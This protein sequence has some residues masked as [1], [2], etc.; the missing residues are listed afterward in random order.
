MIRR[1]ARKRRAVRKAAQNW[2][3]QLNLESLEA[4]QLL[5]GDVIINEISAVNGALPDEDGDT[6]DW[7]ELYNRGDEPVDLGGSYLTDDQGDLRKWRF[8]QSVAVGPGEFLIVYA[9]GKDRDDA[10]GVLHT[11]FQLSSDGEYLALVAAD[12]STVV[13][14]FSPEFP[15]QFGGVTYGRFSRE[16]TTILADG[17]SAAKYIATTAELD[18]GIGSRWTGGQAFDD[19]AWTETSASLGFAQD[20][21]DSTRG[22]F[23]TP[24]YEVPA[25]TSGNQAYSG[26]IGMDFVVTSPI[27]VTSLGVFDDSSDGLRSRVS[28][29]LWSRDDGGTPNDFRDDSGAELLASDTL[30]GTRDL[31][32]GGS[33]YAELDEP[34]ELQPGPYSIVAYGFSTLDRDAVGFAGE[35]VGETADTNAIRF[36]GSA[37]L[38]D[39]SDEFPL[40]PDVGPANRYGAGSFTFLTADDIGSA[41]PAR[42]G[43]VVA[44]QSPAVEGNAATGSNLGVDFQVIRPITVTELGVF[45]SGQDGIAGTLGVSLWSRTT[46]ELLAGKTFI[47]DAGVLEEGTGSRFLPLDEPVFLMPGDYSVVASGFFGNDLYVH[48]SRPGGAHSDLNDS[49]GAIVFEGTSRYNIYAPNRFLEEPHH[50]LPP[51]EDIG[52]VNRWSAGT[53]K[54]AVALLDHVETEV[55]A[56]V[57]D[58]SSNVYMRIPF[59][60]AEVDSFDGLRLHVNYDD[61]FVAYLNGVEVAR[62]NTPAEITWDAAATAV[63]TDLDV[64][65]TEV[66]DLSEHLSLL[67]PNTANVL[68]FQVLNAASDDPDLVLNPL[69]EAFANAG[70]VT[71]YFPEPTPGGPNADVFLGVVPAPEIVTA[72]GIVDPAELNEQGELRVE[73]VNALPDAQI[74]VTTDGS[75][76]SPSNGTLYDGTFSISGTTVLRAAAVKDGF[77]ESRTATAT[78]ILLDDVLATA[79]VPAGF[80][81]HWNGEPPDY[82]ISQDPNDLAAIAGDLSLSV[83]A[84]R[85]VIKESLQSL[86][87]MSIAGDI[88][89]IFGLPDGLYTNP[90]PRGSETEH[91]ASVEFYEADGT[92]GFQI[93]AGLRMMGWTSRIPQVSPKHS[94]RLLFRNE[95]GEGRLEYPLFPGS[96]ITTFDTLALRAN[97]RDS[98]ISDYPFGPGTGLWEE[99]DWGAMRSVAAYIRDQWSREVQADMGMTAAEGRFVHLYINGVYW[100]VYNPTERP[101]GAFAADRFGGDEDDYD[102]ITFCNPTSRATHGD[103]AVWNQLIA[104]V[105]DGLAGDAAY[106]RILGN[107][108]DGTRNPDL[109]VLLD[110]DTFIDFMIS[111]QYDATD[112]W[113]CNFYAFRER[114]QNDT[115]FRF[116]TWDNDLA[117]P[118]GEV[119][120]DRVDVDLTGTPKS[121]PWRFQAVLQQNSDYVMRFADRVQQHFFHDGALTPAA[122]AARW[123]RISDEIAPG[124]IAESARWGDYRRDVASAGPAE[125]YTKSIHWDAFNDHMLTN[126]FP[127][128]TDIVLDQMRARGLYPALAAPELSQHGGTITTGFDLSID[129]PDGTVYFTLDGSDPRAH[130]PNITLLN[131]DSIKRVLVPTNGSLGTNWTSVDFNHTSWTAGR[132]GV[133]YEAGFGDYLDFIDISTRDAM[134]TRS[135]SAYVRIPFN[136]A[137][138]TLPELG[139]LNLKMRY[140]DGFIAY[141]NG[142]EVARANAPNGAAWD[143]LANGGQADGTALVFQDFDLTP[144]LDQLQAGNNVLAIHGLNID[145]ASSDFLIS[146]ELVTGQ[147][148]EGV[149]SAAAQQYMGAITLDQS[150]KVKARVFD[151]SRWSALTEASFAVESPLR[152]SEIYYNPP[153]DIETTEFIEL[154]NTGVTDADLL[155]VGFVTDSSGAGID[156]VFQDGDSVL[157]LAAGQYIVIAK[158]PAAFRAAY[159]DLPA[160]ALIADRGFDGQLSNGGETLRLVDRGGST[161]QEFRYEDDWY[162]V[163][164]GDGF[165]LTIVDTLAELDAWSTT[166]GWMPSSQI[167]GSP[168]TMDEGVTEQAVRREMP[169][170]PAPGDGLP[171]AGP[172]Q[173]VADDGEDDGAET[174]AERPAVTP[175]GPAEPDPPL[176]L[177]GAVPLGLA[178]LLFD[179]EVLPAQEPRTDLVVVEVRPEPVAED[180]PGPELSAWRRS[181]GAGLIH[182]NDNGRL[183]ARERL[184]ASPHLEELLNQSFSRAKL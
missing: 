138:D 7:I 130:V 144:F 46:G 127:A 62:R 128:R 142:V 97:S 57:R 86:P 74:F 25:G 28:V 73:I 41:E 170:V 34:L 48:S 132:G 63:R 153:G 171:A 55:S 122:S 58:V 39:R 64:L 11:N 148:K 129:A 116:L 79:G 124:M 109:P 27:T 125:L 162:P 89:D 84:A 180:D 71:G 151:G 2:C 114:N 184:F 85:E 1:P 141:L 18:A 56:A 72:S 44:Y 154:V 119:G 38:G 113:P 108:P 104:A 14:V 36:V 166:A 98:W 8:P 112:D 100:G 167:G 182:G 50:S 164:D 19:A 134:Y 179:D 120:A 183:A 177:I 173:L 168:G 23:G 26:R 21:L 3:C 42:K 133:G 54:Y 13:D 59:D 60:V 29:E 37:R 52:P 159:P 157:S 80:P 66:L 136:V 102:S 94:M 61:G 135:P 172:A 91:P 121:S 101:D 92:K 10:A 156:F 158:D 107:N 147:S 6:P 51:M 149:I 70:T 105:D 178:D 81:T 169:V 69:L 103:L 111:G 137:P 77:I 87:V 22:L 106:Q 40:V 47:G 165:S 96:E 123:Q 16:E 176:R 75:V 17:N 43:E 140:D 174:V 32:I 99:Y 68:A 53:I 31:L 146:A 82:G 118:L 145:L 88:E 78:F 139:F 24:A 30:R 9:S 65:Q 15:P 163:T 160:D 4:R 110:I 150:T 181:A 20:P 76:P 143:T 45:D 33:R 90:Y 161:I 115:G 67:Q 5:A 95:Y 155:G 12:A 131:D 49:D 175:S 117:I 126:Y 83:D 93:D 35:G 152:V